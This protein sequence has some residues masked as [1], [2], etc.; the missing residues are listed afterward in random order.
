MG[1]SLPDAVRVFLTRVSGPR[2]AKAPFL[3]PRHV[4]L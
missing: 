1:L 2:R 4:L 3:S